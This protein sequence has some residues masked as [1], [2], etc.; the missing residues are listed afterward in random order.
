MRTFVVALIGLLLVAC[1]IVPQASPLLS[2]APTNPPSFTVLAAVDAK[3]RH[4][5]WRTLVS[6]SRWVEFGTIAEGTVYKPRGTVMTVEGRNISEAYI[7]LHDSSWV[8]FWLP[9]EK[10]F[11][12]VETTVPIRLQRGEP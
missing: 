12:P 1:E 5:D 9:V 8:G 11:V 3:P 2:T 7:V 4:G 10:G 6:G